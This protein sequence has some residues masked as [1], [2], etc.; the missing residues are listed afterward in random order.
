MIDNPTSHSPCKE[1]PIQKVF[2]KMLK[3]SQK[4]IKIFVS[5]PQLDALDCIF[6]STFNRF[7]VQAGSTAHPNYSW[8]GI[9]HHRHNIISRHRHV[10]H[11][12]RHTPQAPRNT[13]P[14]EYTVKS[15]LWL[16]PAM[17]MF[18]CPH[19]HPDF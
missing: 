8:I 5:W 12:L 11:H 17:A 4:P 15:L 19:P 14:G 6:F 18:S 10:H 1:E 2:K 13:T 16:L 9:S 7:R 3:S